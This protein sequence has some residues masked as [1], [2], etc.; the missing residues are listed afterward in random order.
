MPIFACSR[1]TCLAFGWLVTRRRLKTGVCTSCPVRNMQ[2]L[3]HI[4][5]RVTNT[6]QFTLPGRRGVGGSVSGRRR[7]R[8]SWGAVACDTC[9]SNRPAPS[10]SAIPLCGDRLP[11]IARRLPVSLACSRAGYS[12]L[13]R[14]DRLAAIFTSTFCLS[15]LW[16][17]VWPGFG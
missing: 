15:V 11:S 2:E 7:A 17:P 12:S 14:V 5:G 1:V 10:C 16:Q 3:C 4:K 6:A 13:I 9:Q 8:F